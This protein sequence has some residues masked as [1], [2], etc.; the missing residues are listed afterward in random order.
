MNAIMNKL[1]QQGIIPA[2]RVV[3]TKDHRVGDRM[4]GI[5]GG[6]C[7][8]DRRRLRP[9]SAFVWFITKK[10]EAKASP[11]HVGSEIAGQPQLQAILYCVSD[12]ASKRELYVGASCGDR[13][14][15]PVIKERSQRHRD[16]SIGATPNRPRSEYLP[17]HFGWFKL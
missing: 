4:R 3:L 12:H 5:G 16:H 7:K 9:F 6:N 1:I 14:A 2:S 13:F 11:F 17:Q 8:F 10:G 15:P